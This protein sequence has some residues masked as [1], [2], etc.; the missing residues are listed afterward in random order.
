MHDHI[1]PKLSRLPFFLGDGLLVGLACFIVIQGHQPLD[2]WQMLACTICIVAGAGLGVLPFLLEYRLLGRLV[3]A[4]R[5]TT[6][7]GQI[8]KLEQLTAQISSASSR[9]NLVQESAEKTAQY[10]ASVIA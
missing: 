6:V 2:Q 9:W 1:A 5:L 4:D 3:E 10:A 8:Q 7:V